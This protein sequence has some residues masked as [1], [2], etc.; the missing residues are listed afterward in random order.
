[1]LLLP[2]VDDLPVHGQD[3]TSWARKVSLSILTKGRSSPKVSVGEVLS[4][5]TGVAYG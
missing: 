3:V 5:E 2:L 1:M 4:M